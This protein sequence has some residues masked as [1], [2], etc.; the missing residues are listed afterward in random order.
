M[1]AVP[2]LCSV[3]GTGDDEPVS[4]EVLKALYT[5]IAPDS[6]GTVLCSSLCKPSS[7]TKTLLQVGKMPLPKQCY[8]VCTACR[9]VCSRLHL[10][11]MLSHTVRATATAL[12]M[13][14]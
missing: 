5:I 4:I 7:F 14:M 11:P 1:G 10:L 13:F 9:T 12:M 3:L 2:A 8:V 6:S